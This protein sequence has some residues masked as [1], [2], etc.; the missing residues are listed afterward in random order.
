MHWIYL[1][2]HFDD[3]ALSCGGLVWEQ[4]QA[5][6]TVSIWTV[7]AGSAPDGELSP[8]AKELHM[9]WK[10]DQDATSQRRLEDF[11]S[12]QRLG[13]SYLHFTLPD[14]IYRHNPQTGEFMYASAESITGQLQSADTY[15]LTFLGKEIKR[16]IQAQATLVCPLSLGN[17]VDHQLTRL[18]TEGLGY[19]LWYYQDYPYVLSS[20][21]ML[22]HMEQEGW[23]TH[24]FPI[25]LQGLVAWQD[26]IAAYT[27]QI[28]TFWID[29]LELRQAVSEYLEQNNGILLWRKPKSSATLAFP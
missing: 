11:Q 3:V 8:I 25:S 27:S 13:A 14:C 17:H 4:A 18:A 15:N 20:M 21:D 22:K 10:T 19:S 5:G 24:C 16:S 6:D 23:E 29:V 28:S 7:C 26:S 2:P 1:S 12:C 9:R